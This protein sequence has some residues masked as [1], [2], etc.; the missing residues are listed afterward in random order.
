MKPKKTDF[1]KVLTTL[2]R[3]L[4]KAYK[5]MIK[6]SGNDIESM[7]KE[8]REKVESAFLDECIKRGIY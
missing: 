4:W 8:D 3:V 1:E 5:A 6:H 7:P 2:Q